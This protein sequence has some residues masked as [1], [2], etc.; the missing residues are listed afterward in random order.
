PQNHFVT[1]INLEHQQNNIGGWGFLIPEYQRTTVGA[2][3]YHQLE[4][5]HNL[6][7]MS[8]LRYDFGLM[9]TK[10]YYDW[11]QSSVTNNDGSTSQVYL[12][13]SLDKTLDFSNFSG[14]IGL[15]Y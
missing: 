2:F 12:Q 7:L 10:A 8:G 6:H 5:N 3:A 14:A 9:K 1:G 11:F 15:S 4:I 13:R